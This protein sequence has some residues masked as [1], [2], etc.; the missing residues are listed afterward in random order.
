MSA[1]LEFTEYLDANG[2]SP[3]AKWFDRLDAVVAAKVR[4]NIQRVELGNY[5]NVEAIGDGLSEIKINFGAGY[6]VYFRKEKDLLLL[7]L[8]GSSK[9]GQQNAI[10]AAKMAWKIYERNRK[11]ITLKGKGKKN[12]IN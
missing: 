3:F 6:R 5:S 12:A 9:N 7:L 10:N 11:Q 2:V 4:V 1:P 8:G